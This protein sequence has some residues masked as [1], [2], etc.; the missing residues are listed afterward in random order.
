M[1][2][3]KVARGCVW[4]CSHHISGR[5]PLLHTDKC[6]GDEPV[7]SGEKGVHVSIAIAFQAEVPYH[8]LTGVRQMSQSTV[9]REC[10]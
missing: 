3:S 10:V 2:Q 4:N 1:S 9:A 8:T 5:S 7:K 6:E